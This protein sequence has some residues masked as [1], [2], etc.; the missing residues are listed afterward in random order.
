[1]NPRRL[2]SPARDIADLYFHQPLSE[3]FGFD[4][5]FCQEESTAPVF[6]LHLAQNCHAVHADEL[7]LALLHPKQK[8]DQMDIDPRDQLAEGRIIVTI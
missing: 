3:S 8:L 5:Y 4:Q 2:P 6:D 1:M 7:E